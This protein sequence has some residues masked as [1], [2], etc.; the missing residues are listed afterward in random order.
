MENAIFM[1]R[2]AGMD[3]IIHLDTDELIYPAGAREYSLKQLLLDLPSD[4]DLVVFPNYESIVEQDD[5]KDPFGEVS[6]FKKNYDHL[7]K[8]TYFGLYR[9]TTRGNA[10]YFLTYGNG[11]EAACVQDEL[12][13][14]GAHRWHNYMKTPKYG[15]CVLMENLDQ[16]T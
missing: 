8:E 12:R 4:V 10:N 15:D 9:E 16:I 7:P 13:R 5:I 2:D 6:M 1:A 14:N 11:K 3:W